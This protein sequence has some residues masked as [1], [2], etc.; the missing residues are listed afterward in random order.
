MNKYFSI[1]TLTHLVAAAFAALLV[2]W[3]LPSHPAQVS[4]QFKVLINLQSDGIPSA[5]LCH[6]ST[7]TNTLGKSIIV[8]C[9]PGEAVSTTGDKTAPLWTS[10]L[11]GAQ[12]FAT[13][14]TGD[15]V[16][17]YTLNSYAEGATLTSWRVVNLAN[18]DYLELKVDW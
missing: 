17:S 4:T 8:T 1:G 12:Y 2:L 13:Q 16:S 10:A 18:R 9:S 6:S 3:A 15:D 14:I 11:D 5:G 7:Q